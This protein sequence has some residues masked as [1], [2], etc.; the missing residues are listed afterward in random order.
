MRRGGQRV[1]RKV[2]KAMRQ[3]TDEQ[4]DEL[5]ELLRRQRWIVFCFCAL[6]VCAH[7]A[8]LLIGRC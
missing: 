2:V 6:T 7:A 1:A 8:L 3:M 5:N 4:H